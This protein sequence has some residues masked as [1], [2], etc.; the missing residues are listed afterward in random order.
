M[1]A[2]ALVQELIYLTTLWRWNIGVTIGGI[3]GIYLGGDADFA[4]QGYLVKY[5]IFVILKILIAFGILTKIWENCK[6]IFTITNNIMQKY[7]V[8]GQNNM[9]SWYVVF[10]YYF[11]YS[12]YLMP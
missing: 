9:N 12:L 3:V 4:F 11:S 6:L 8:N 1:Y 7:A 10:T 5:I 2:L